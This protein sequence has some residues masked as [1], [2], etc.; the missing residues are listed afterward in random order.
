MQI[1]RMSQEHIR[2]IVSIEKEIQYEPWTESLFLAELRQPGSL[3]FTLIVDNSVSGYLC[4]TIVEGEL[5]INNLG[6]APQ[7]QNQGYG[8]KLL[9]SLLAE[10][11]KLGARVAYLE[12][13]ESNF[14]AL[15]LYQKLGFRI[16]GRRYGYYSTP[17]GKEDAIL[18]SL[19]L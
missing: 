12:V 9:T 19:N 17:S 2:A 18:M 3:C 1:V 15:H 13:R 7:L 11:K 6:I 8:T 14:P 10:A 16:R 4:S 5:H